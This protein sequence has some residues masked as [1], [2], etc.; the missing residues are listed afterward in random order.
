[1]LARPALNTDFN[2]VSA[3]VLRAPIGP[4]ASRVRSLR[5][6]AET[7]LHLARVF[8]L[9][10]PIILRVQRQLY[11]QITGNQLYGIV[12]AYTEHCND[13]SQ[14]RSTQKGKPQIAVRP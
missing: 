4:L 8:L 7:L 3:H 12:Q 9:R 14:S 13:V 10:L 6:P 1:M 2:M 5:L 11:K